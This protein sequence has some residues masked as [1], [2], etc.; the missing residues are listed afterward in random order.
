[1]SILS[2]LDDLI[3]RDTSNPPLTD[4]GATLTYGEFDGNFVKL[5][6]ALQDVVSGENVEAYDAGA[7]Y[8]KY[9]T[10]VYEKF[11]GYDG[12]I[13]EA[14]YNGSPSAFSGQ[15]PA[16]GLYWTQ[17]TVAQL[18]PNILML[19]ELSNVAGRGMCPQFCTEWQAFTEQ[20][21]NSNPVDITGLPAPGAGKII[22]PKFLAIS[23][24]AGGTPFNFGVLGLHLAFSTTPTTPV[25]IVDPTVINS[26]SDITTT[27]GAGG[28][29]SYI[30]NDKMVLGAAADA[31][32]GDGTYYI[33]V[34][35]QIES[36]AF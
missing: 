12:R 7:T 3:L 4:K 20:D 13:W 6:N 35:Y 1:M 22:I 21:L 16:E 29:A 27:Y 23:L 31:T 33:K 28:G 5:Y 25:I 8:D 10:D 14:V 36:T 32:L 24:D 19:A 18:L 26:A 2:E 11:V 34:I 9:S 30:A 17:I 15:T